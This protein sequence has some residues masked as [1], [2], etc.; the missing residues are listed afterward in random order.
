MVRIGARGERMCTSTDTYHTDC[1]SRLLYYITYS[2]A[3]DPAL[4]SGAQPDAAHQAIY[5]QYLLYSHVTGIMPDF[6]TSSLLSSTSYFTHLL[7][8]YV[9]SPPLG[10]IS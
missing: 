5:L 3:T 2:R 4:A 7:L 8:D 6:T 10:L 9:L 1:I